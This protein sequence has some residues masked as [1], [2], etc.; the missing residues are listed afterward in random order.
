VA[1]DSASVVF[2]TCGTR[3]KGVVATAGWIS[4]LNWP[5]GIAN[6]VQHLKN[7]GELSGS[8]NTYW[9]KET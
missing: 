5:I 7:W 8:Q 3:R 2:Q 9:F 6:A 1:K 4:E